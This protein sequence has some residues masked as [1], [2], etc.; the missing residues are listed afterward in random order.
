MSDKFKL[1][2]FNMITRPD[3][4][5]TGS[6]V[7]SS[8]PVAQ[9]RDHRLS[10]R[11]KFTS[12]PGEKSIVLNLTAM[13]ADPIAAQF[14][15]AD[16]LA[17]AGHNLS[18]VHSMILMANDAALWTTPNITLTNFPLPG[19]P[20]TDPNIFGETNITLKVYKTLLFNLGQDIL[21][22][23]NTHIK[24]KISTPVG[25]DPVEIGALHLG[26]GL[27]FEGN[28]RYGWQQGYND[29]SGSLRSSGVLLFRDAKKGGVTIRLQFD[30]SSIQDTHYAK[31]FE[32]QFG[33]A[34]PLFVSLEPEQE[35]EFYEREQIRSHGLT[36]YGRGAFRRFSPRFLKS[37]IEPYYRKEFLF[38]EDIGGPGQ[39]PYAVD[40]PPVE[41]I[42]GDFIIV[43]AT[44]TNQVIT[45]GTTGED[46]SGFVAG[47]DPD[48]WVSTNGITIG[49]DIGRAHLRAACI[50]Q[51]STR[52]DVEVQLLV[53]GVEVARSSHPTQD[54]T[55]T[56][57]GTG[58][59]A[60]KVMPLSAGDVIKA[61]V[62]HN[63]G[64]DATM[65]FVHLNLV[66][67]F[68]Q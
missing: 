36:F 47:Y 38:R 63:K 31:Y 4:A 35:E 66:E 12:D 57:Y 30:P 37:S 42:E 64:S 10:R 19:D 41:E 27:Q 58:A 16:T 9:L 14:A 60:S 25:Y 34:R 29:L 1:H 13:L 28:Y 61:H 18:N 46:I 15:H 6:G 11:L 50:P 3:V 56:Q 5:L 21:A 49:E 24:L 54:T 68:T 22:G 53:N 32:H 43:T 45:T 62:K 17:L 48:G 51:L 7:E 39:P 26:W 2:C 23:G 65:S 8:W 44:A 40:Q 59:I 52:F 20:D 33:M 55:D 67:G